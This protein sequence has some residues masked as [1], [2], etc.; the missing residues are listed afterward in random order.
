[1]QG[2]SP[3]VARIKDGANPATWMLE[4]T[5]GATSTSGAKAANVDWINYYA[6]SE[7]SAENA[8]KADRL[9][10][11]DSRSKLPLTVSGGK[12]AA[13]FGM[14][15]WELMKKYNRAYWRTPSYNYMRWV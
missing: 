5:G 3:D 1:M 6:N 9:I 14:Q 8:A 2:G 13:P 4:V 12:Y 11:E 10:E 7:L 15:F